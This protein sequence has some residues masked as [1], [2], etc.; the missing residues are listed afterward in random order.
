[1]ANAVDYM[2]HVGTKFVH[3]GVIEKIEKVD[4][5]LHVTI[6]F[7]DGRPSY[8]VSGRYF[9]SNQKKK[10]KKNCKCTYALSTYSNTFNRKH[11]R[12]C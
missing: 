1:M 9:Q 8:T 12:Q 10:K 3:G 4:D 2:E 11:L 5:K 7:A 6:N